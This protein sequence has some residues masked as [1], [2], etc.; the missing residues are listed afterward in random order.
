MGGVFGVE[1]MHAYVWWSPFAVHPKLSKHCY[2]AILQYKIIIFFFKNEVYVNQ[3]YWS[4]L[5]LAKRKLTTL[6]CIWNQLLSVNCVFEKGT[7]PLSQ[8]Q[9][10]IECTAWFKSQL[11]Y[12]TALLGN[13]L[14][15]FSVSWLFP[16]IYKIGIIALAS[17]GCWDS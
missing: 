17:W 8:R 12:L 4:N 14:K 1:L 13:Y 16:S 7:I 2:L 10:S 3:T 9:C 6:Q 5:L 11:H 15:W